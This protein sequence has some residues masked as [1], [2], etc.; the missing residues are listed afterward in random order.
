MDMV[1]R[2]TRV[3]RTLS[4]LVVL[5]IISVFFFSVNMK[6]VVKASGNTYY[7]ST[8]GD[9]SN[10][11]T[12]DEPFKTLQTAIS[13]MQPGDTLLIRGGVYNYEETPYGRYSTRADIDSMN[14]NDSEWYTIENYPNEKVTF[15]AEFMSYGV[16]GN[17]LVFQGSSYWKIQGIEFK[18]YTGAAI[19]F[20]GDTNH[21]VLD[22][23]CMHDIEGQATGDNGTEAIFSYGNVNNVTVSNC[24]IYNVGIKN[25]R[26]DR[27]HGIY[28]GYGGA[29]DWTIT[30]NII[31]DNASS[32]IQF[33]GGSYGGRNCIISNNIIYNNYKCGIIIATNSSNN[34]IQN[35]KFYNNASYD[36]YLNWNSTNNVFKNNIFGSYNC[37]DNV[38]IM[39]S[40]STSNT[41][42]YNMYYKKNTNLIWYFNT[43]LN[44]D[45]FKAI[46]QENNGVYIYYS[47]NNPFTNKLYTY[48]RLEGSNRLATS[49]KIAESYNSGSVSN[50]VIASGTSFPDA[51]SG[52]ALV[53]KYKCPI[54][55]V[56]NNSADDQNN[57]IEY[58]KDHLTA[59]GNVFILGGEKAVSKVFADTLVNMNKGY[60]ITR[61][62]GQ[63]RLETNIQIIN[64]LNV[65]EGTPMILAYSN[66]FPDALSISSLSAITGY[67][68]CLVGKDNLSDQAIAALN[69]IKPS[70]V[71]IVGGTGVISDNVFNQT[72][73]YCSDVVRLG[74]ANRF[75]T[76]L[77]IS[78]YFKSYFTSDT[79]TVTYGG[80]FPDALSGSALSGKMKSPI[81]LVPS[82]SGD[83]ADLSEIKSFMDQSSYKKY[84]ILGGKNSVPYEIQS[85][86]LR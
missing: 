38:A 74:G 58:I 32:G 76:S 41:F 27:D 15:N 69:K 73:T 71:Y 26:T 21:I 34:L 11:G 2:F 48:N 63:N 81:L 31:H 24:S 65:A 17:G 59:G 52:S 4:V 51:L 49:V 35:N 55:L 5:C 37:E 54:L 43:T 25:M 78:N 61:L 8:Q 39:D 64:N 85:Y 72:K 47:G 40:Q 80:N 68:V 16:G 20:N 86:L 12:I 67:P 10:P 70:T 6:Y 84:L 46:S 60:N 36:V 30:N 79:V 42:D 53:Y 3:E 82:N 75:E 13:R 18:G 29:S 77:K 83:Q 66:N 50:V 56:G 33:Y 62:Y 57:A 44:L 22:N 23:L 1:S 9:D 19:Y 14:G 28:V 45:K 7:L